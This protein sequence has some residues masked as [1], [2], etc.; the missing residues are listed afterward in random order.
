MTKVSVVAKKILCSRT[1]ARKSSIGDLD[2]CAREVE[3]E[4]LIKTPLI[5]SVEYF[6][7]RVLCLLAGKS[8]PWR[9]DAHAGRKHFD[10]LNSDPGPTQKARPDLQLCRWQPKLSKTERSFE[11][12]ITLE[13]LP[14]ESIRQT[15]VLKY[16]LRVESLHALFAIAVSLLQP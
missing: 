3:I 4:N 11:N 14:S 6:N 7:L 1:V 13:E 12:K 16:S 5:Y 8:P 2:F 15:L 9:R 10:K